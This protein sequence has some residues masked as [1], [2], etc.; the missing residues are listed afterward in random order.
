MI[1]FDFDLSPDPVWHARISFLKSFIRIIAG[2][3]LIFSSL[4]MAGVL[5]ILA[6][7]LGVAEE[8]V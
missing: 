7:L 6:E 1:K 5:L 3:F 4:G 2:I 8:L